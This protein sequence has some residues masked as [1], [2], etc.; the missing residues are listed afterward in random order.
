MKGTLRTYGK[1]EAKSNMMKLTFF[2]TSHGAPEIGRFCSGTLLETDGVSYVIDCGAPVDA[3]MLNR[4]KRFEDLRGVFITHMHE[5]HMGT[6][7]A[8]VKEFGH[9]H[10]TAHAHFFL[11]EEA[12][13]DALR[14]WQN[15]MHG[16]WDE[17]RVVFGTSKP[18]VFFEDEH[19]RVTGIQTDHIPGY[20][21]YAYAMELKA[22]GKRVLFTGDMRGDLKDFP[23]A[24][25]TENW[26]VI[27]SE[28]THFHIEQHLEAFLKCRTK[29]L[30]F[31]HKIEY[32]IEKMEEILPKLPFETIV[33]C[34]GDTFIL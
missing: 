6:L 21:T 33:A 1:G 28:L 19:V 8:M 31:N 15:A 12:A 3:L 20:P 17:D 10:P 22:E 34:A 26:D 25:H 29:T 11:P 16:T 14:I 32:N 27:V 9:Y 24:A 5:D 2:G 30:I 23:A 4:G 7:P 13:L 18:G